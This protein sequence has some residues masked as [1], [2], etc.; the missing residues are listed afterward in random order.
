MKIF[1]FGEKIP[2]LKIYGRPAH[3]AVLNERDAR[4][5]AG[6][7]LIAGIVAFV[8]ALLLQEFIYLYIFVWLF[9]L[10]FGIRV[11][12][13]PKLAPFYALG[14]LLVANQIPEYSGASQKRFAWS[15]GFG[16]ATI[17]I[18]VIFVFG[19]RGAVPFTI[20]GI[21][22]TLLWLEASLGLCV[23]CKMY[24]G[25]ITLGVMNTPK[26]MP[27]CPGGVCE[28]PRKSRK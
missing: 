24:S 16:L 4:A 2:N 17:M 19:M 15:L 28:L 21:C 27:A 7:M 20:C 14:S 25:L 12:I 18:L 1:Q 11:F 13:N 3:Y 22:L 6:L 26:E 9:A 8:N 10:E 5:A 23:G